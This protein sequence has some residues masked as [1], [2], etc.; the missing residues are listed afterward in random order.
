MKRVAFLF[1]ILAAIALLLSGPGTRF[2]W[3]PLTI[4]LGLYA[5][6]VPL[7]I[8]ALFLAL[9][10]AVREKRT[11][12]L[13]T[14]S[15]GFSAVLLIVTVWHVAAAFHTPPIHDITTDLAEPPQFTKAIVY[16]GASVAA[17]QRV[18]YPEIEPLI[19]HRV[20][21]VDAFARAMAAA[22]RLGWDVT[23][24]RPDEGRLEATATTSWFGFTDDV[25]VRIRPSGDGSRV[26][27]RSRSRVGQG[28]A[29]ENAKRIRAFLQLLRR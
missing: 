11:S 10:A 1:A 17:R 12:P 20:S 6:C 22:H 23:M 18:A 8:I 15:I 14:L 25:V 7:A 3:F 2:G 26:D 13:T 27:V 28:D 19:L 24:A 29:G 9:I 21:P 5:L 4:G 16:P